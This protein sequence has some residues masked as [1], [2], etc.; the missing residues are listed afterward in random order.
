MGPVCWLEVYIKWRC[1]MLQERYLQ[2]SSS[3]ACICYATLSLERGLE[4]TLGLRRDSCQV[5]PGTGAPVCNSRVL[6][7][8]VVPNDDGSLL[9]LDPRVEIRSVGKMVI[10]E[11]EDRVGLLLLQPDNVPGD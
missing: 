6:S 3:R 10:Q 11:L 1:K 2:R 4:G 7:H 5:P 8:S 9:P